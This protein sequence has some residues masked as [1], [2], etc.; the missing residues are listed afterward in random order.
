[1]A[2]YAYYVRRRIRAFL[3]RKKVDPAVILPITNK[4]G[5]SREIA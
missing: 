3:T 1:M 2:A 4:T 5:E